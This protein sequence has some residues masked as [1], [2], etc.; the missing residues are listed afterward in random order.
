MQNAVAGFASPGPQQHLQVHR[1]RKLG[2]LTKSAMRAVEDLF[3]TNDRGL[4]QRQGKDLPA[5]L[6]HLP[7]IPQLRG[8]LAGLL[9]HL[10]PL[11]QPGAVDGQN[12]LIETGHRRPRPRRKVGASIKRLQIGSQEHRHRP[13]AATRQNLHGRHIDVVQVRPLL[14]I[15]LD[16]HEPLVQHLGDPRV[17]EAFVFHHV[18]PMASGVA[19]GKENRLLFL[20]GPIQR[21]RSP[22]IPVHRIVS[23][24]E[25]VGAGLVGESIRHGYS[26]VCSWSG[27][28]PLRTSSRN[29]VTA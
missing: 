22:G 8:Q 6:A 28:C 26:N 16:V 14:A 5:S 20:A 3:E 4:Q 9:D 10:I 2:R 11:L 19:D 24:L 12:H 18:A 25:Q 23:M 13:A 21:L 29:V 27:N 15:D 1:M 17:L 7:R